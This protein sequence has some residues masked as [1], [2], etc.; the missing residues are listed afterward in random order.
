MQALKEGGIIELAPMESGEIPRLEF[1]G[2]QKIKLPEWL[3]FWFLDPA[4]GKVM[5]ETFD[6]QLLDTPWYDQYR[7]RNDW[8]ITDGLRTWPQIQPAIDA[9]ASICRIGWNG[10]GMFAFQ[11]PANELPKEV[12]EKLNPMSE[13]VRKVLLGLNRPVL[14]TQYYCLF[15]AQGSVANGWMP[16]GLDL[17]AD[18]WMVL[19]HR[20]AGQECPECHSPEIDSNSPETKYQCGST[21]YDQRPGTFK[22]G[23]NCNGNG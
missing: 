12:I 6:G 10:K 15:T 8:Q 9:G 20:V 2:P 1:E 13:P 23:A 19:H 22:K 3:G 18:D 21:D 17:H 5:V 11:R 7:D 16:N 4:T 14:F